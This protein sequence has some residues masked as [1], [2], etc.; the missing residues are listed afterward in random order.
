MVKPIITTGLE[1]LGRGNDLNKLDSF[2]APILQIEEA[3]RRIKWDNYLTR[4]ST[5][6]GMD[7]EGLIVTEEE[8]QAQQQ[9]EQM[10]AMASQAIG[11]GVT[12]IGGM[13]KQGM[14]DGKA[15]PPAAG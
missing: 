14:S 13:V 7:T 2:I 5:A 12:A 6:L 15:S 1:A 3:R 10:Q 4:R 8:F 9:Q 11:P